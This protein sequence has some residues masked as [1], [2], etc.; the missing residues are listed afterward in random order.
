MSAARQEGDGVTAQRQGEQPGTGRAAQRQRG[1]LGQLVDY[2][3]QQAGIPEASRPGDGAAPPDLKTLRQFRSTWT[4]LSVD[5]QLSRSKE[6]V[7]DNPG[8]LNSHLL[9]LRSL[10]LMQQVSPAYLRRFMSHVEALLWLDQ[11]SFGGLPP[12]GKT[13]LRQ[14]EKKRKPNR[15]K[16]GQERR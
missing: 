10:K 15:G 3:D 5:R 16:T 12:P 4:S 13:V 8:P 6:Q 1:L 2:I 9:V 11:A 7:P 14:S